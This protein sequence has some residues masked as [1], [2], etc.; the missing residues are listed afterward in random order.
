MTVKK[1][2]T[3]KTKDKKPILF[4]VFFNPN[5]IPKP[6]VVFCHGYKGFKDW[7]G[8]D[9]VAQHFS[10]LGYFFLKFNFSHNGGTVENPID[11]P[12]PEAFAQ[13]N[14]ST[15]LDDLDRVINHIVKTKAHRPEADATNINLIGHS[16]GGGIVLIKAEEDKRIKKVVSWAGVSDYKARFQEGTAAFAEWKKTGR[17]YI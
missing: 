5:N 15:E 8:W 14:F 9:M 4:D 3:L 2:N 11:F 1:H 16:R 13:N 12:D 7:G 17:T 10:A 6:I